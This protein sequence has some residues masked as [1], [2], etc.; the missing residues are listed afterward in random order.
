MDAAVKNGLSSD[1]AVARTI[2][3]RSESA[4]SAASGC[5]AAGL[6]ARAWE[7]AWDQVCLIGLGLGYHCAKCP[8]A[9]SG[10][11]SS[12]QLLQALGVPKAT[13]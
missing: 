10:E 12:W 13:L 6:P 3:G 7:N 5:S 2:A 8:A 1:K 11:R 4:M 9:H